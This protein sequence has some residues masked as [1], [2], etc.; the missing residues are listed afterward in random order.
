MHKKR[1]G[2]SRPDGKPERGDVRAQ[3]SPA[4]DEAQGAEAAIA[5]SPSAEAR[6]AAAEPFRINPEGAIGARL[7][8]TEDP[9]I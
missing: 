2:K 7:D 8:F 6:R 5:G 9:H 1:A 4:G 3:G